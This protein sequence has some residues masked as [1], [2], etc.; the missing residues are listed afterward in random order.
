MSTRRFFARRFASAT[1]GSSE[2]GRRGMCISITPLSVA[3]Y[4]TSNGADASGSFRGTPQTPVALPDTV[5]DRDD[6]GT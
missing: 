1:S 3:P 2:K 5:G 4:L 6:G